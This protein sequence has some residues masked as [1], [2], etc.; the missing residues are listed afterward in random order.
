M[1]ITSTVLLKLR[2]EEAEALA[3]G[4]QDNVM[5]ACI[6]EKHP[7]ETLRYL[8]LGSTTASGVELGPLA[9]SSQ[10]A[11]KHQ[12]VL[13][14]LRVGATRP[15]SDSPGPGVYNPNDF[16]PKDGKYVLSK[17]QNCLSASFFTPKETVSKKGK[18]AFKEQFIHLI[19]GLASMILE[20]A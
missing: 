3:S 19:Q 9:T 1:R 20:I 2:P 12:S 6:S 16:I 18:R 14:N 17:Y 8:D 4:L 10:C 5:T 11:R 13:T 15:G 7:D